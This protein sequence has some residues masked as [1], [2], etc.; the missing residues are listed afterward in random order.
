M[1]TATEAII[2]SELDI[3]EDL[4]PYNDPDDGKDH[5]AH[6]VRPADN[7]NI[8]APGLQPMAKDIVDTARLMRY[9]IVALCGYKFIPER[10]P[11][12]YPPCETC[13]DIAGMIVIGGS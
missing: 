7:E 4:A 10:N 9:E 3:I 2:T 8:I 13:L 6:I 5:F 1:T 11:K 12:K